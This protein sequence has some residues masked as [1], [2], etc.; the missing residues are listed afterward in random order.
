MLLPFAILLAMP[1]LPM[2]ASGQD[3]LRPRPETGPVETTPLPRPRPD[4]RSAQEA[5]P[6]A[7]DEKL[8]AAA[9]VYQTAC[10][11]LQMGAVEGHAL[12][13]IS[14]GSC[15]E[16]SPLAVTGVLV[17]GRMVP[18]SSEARLTCAMATTLPDWA[19]RVDAYATTIEKSRIE[20]IVVGTSYQ[21]RERRTGSET[22][23]LSEHAF[24]NGL[25][26]TGFALA[27]G[28]MVSVEQGW[29][30]KDGGEVL[31][32]FAHDAACTAFM[33]VLGPDANAL[34]RDHLHLDQGCHGKACMTRL[35]Q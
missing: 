16:R 23:D 21:C 15:G 29:G 6:D 25:D 19:N 26:V 32:R 30:A 34:H 2:P 5:P 1:L 24:A 13:P 33:T 20:T 8:P 18:L 28:R 27:D 4:H 9:R 22:T 11:A 35:C 3:L 31:L 7:Q 12:P 17:N 10:P 14:E